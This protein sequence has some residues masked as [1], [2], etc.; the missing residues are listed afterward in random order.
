MA[1]DFYRTGSEPVS[2]SPTGG[3]D[4]GKDKGK[5]WTLRRRSKDEKKLKGSHVPPACAW[6]CACAASRSCDCV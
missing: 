4:K 6:A 2:S 1:D 3:D 5:K